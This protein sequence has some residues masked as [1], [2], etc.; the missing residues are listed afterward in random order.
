MYPNMYISFDH[1]SCVKKTDYKFK[2][3]LPK[4]CK[5][6]VKFCNYETICNLNDTETRT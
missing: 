1:L 2:E 4:C 6:C 5:K 3:P